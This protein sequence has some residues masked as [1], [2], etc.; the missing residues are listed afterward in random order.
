MMACDGEGGEALQSKEVHQKCMQGV[1]CIRRIR[2]AIKIG[3]MW[4]NQLYVEQRFASTRYSEEHADCQ[5][6][7]EVFLNNDWLWI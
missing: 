3:C 1:V 7:P 6:H 2:G 4:Q 5:I